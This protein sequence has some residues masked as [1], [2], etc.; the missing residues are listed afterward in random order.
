[1]IVTGENF[2]PSLTTSAQSLQELGGGYCCTCSHSVSHRHSA[3]LPPTV[4]LQDTQHSQET[5]IHAP[6]VN[7]ILNPTKRPAA[8]LRLRPRS[9]RYRRKLKY[10]EKRHVPVT[11]V[12]KLGSVQH[13]R[14]HREPSLGQTTQGYQCPIFWEYL[15]STGPALCSRSSP[16]N[17]TV[18]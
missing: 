15:L 14:P 12:Q 7:R 11:L 16:M 1:M 9:Y 4:S 5:D 8:D 2:F 17:L 6:G 10:F 3:G 18:R 13:P